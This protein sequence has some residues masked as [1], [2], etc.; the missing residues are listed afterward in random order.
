V[1][2]SLLGMA[3]LLALDPVRLGVVVLLISRPRPV[4]NLFVY[5]VACFL[6]G[7]LGLLV[8][9]VVL[10]G[11]PI[12]D[13]FAEHLATSSTV[14]YVQIGLG[15]FALSVAVLM[16]VHSLTQ[17]RRRARLPAPDGRSS[18]LVLESNTPTAI[19]RLL[20]RA[21]DAATDGGSMIWRLIG[22]VYNAWENG[23]LWVAL[24]IGLGPLP[25]ETIA[26][27]L[28]IVVPSGAAIGTQVVASIVFVVVM[29][30]VI[31]VALVS[32]LAMP[33][34]TLSVLGLLHDW[35]RAHGRQVLIAMF[36]IGGVS[37]VG[38]GMGVVSA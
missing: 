8:P 36:A 1:W 27:V 33:T 35:V 6:V 20:D 4:Q 3:L 19:S 9:L 32:Y 24:V 17:A 14:R 22:R 21:Q 7:V 16:T 13:D 10:H 38:H 31:E 5:W 25:I 23:A 15:V 12:L 34:K 18:T 29:L 11:T 30:A 2:S 28:A 37:L 26:F